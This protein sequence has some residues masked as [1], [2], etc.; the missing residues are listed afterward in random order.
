M[1]ARIDEA[2]NATCTEVTGSINVLTAIRLVALGWREVKA[3]TIQKCFR[4]AGVLSDDFEVQVVGEEDPF[5]DIDDTVQLGS[6]IQSAMGESSCSV[7]EYVAGE[8]ALPVCADFDCEDWDEK[9]LNSL[10]DNPDSDTGDNPDS[11]TEEVDYDLLPPPPKLTCFKQAI[12]ALEDVQVFLE[13]RGYVEQATPVGKVMINLAGISVYN[14][15]QTT[16][17]E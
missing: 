4:K 7:E 10:N 14:Y 8:D 11:D 9:W 5:V 3:S 6:L 12:E 15:T 13:H 2:K 1:L 16:I 17:D